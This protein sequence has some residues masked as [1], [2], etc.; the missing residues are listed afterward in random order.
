MIVHIGQEKN[1]CMGSRISKA[2]F[3]NSAVWIMF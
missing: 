3:E 1:K 2:W